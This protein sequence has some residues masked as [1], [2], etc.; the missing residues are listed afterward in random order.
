MKR[1]I[2]MILIAFIIAFSANITA[3]AGDGE[4]NMSGGGGGMGSGT[5]ENVWHNGDDGVRVTVVRASDNKPV[6]TPIDLTNK[7]EDDIV[8]HFDK[9]CFEKISGK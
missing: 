9:V 5:A 7:K 6:M 2:A 3:H 4:G 1:I 8:V